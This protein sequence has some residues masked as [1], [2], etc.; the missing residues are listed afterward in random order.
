MENILPHGSHCKECKEI[1]PAGTTHIVK[2][3]APFKYYYCTP[4]GT[5]EKPAPKA[6]VPSKTRT[7]KF[8]IK[9][10]K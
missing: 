9:K 7:K 10:R 1:V 6:P 8:R 4:C 5:G 3:A 2:D